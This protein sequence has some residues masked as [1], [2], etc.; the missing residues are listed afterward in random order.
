MAALHC[1]LELDRLDRLATDVVYD[2][3]RWVYDK[4]RWRRVGGDGTKGETSH[5]KFDSASQPN[6]GSPVWR[7]HHNSKAS[8]NDSG[9]GPRA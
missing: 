3:D 1:I 5:A 9:M 4:R 6:P 8:I 7:C 2:E